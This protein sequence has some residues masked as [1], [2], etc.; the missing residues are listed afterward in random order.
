MSDGRNTFR[1][2]C[3]IELPGNASA[4][5]TDHIN[6]L[7][8]QFP[9]V[10]ASWNRDGKFHLTLKFIGELPHTWVELLSLA[11][12]RATSNLSS[13]NITVTGA[14]AFPEKGSPRVLWLGIDDRTGQLATLQDRLEQEC[15]RE[16]FTREERAFHPHLTIA[17]LRKPDGARELATA[18]AE[19]GFAAVEVS[20]TEL[21]VIRSELSSAGSKYTTISRHPLTGKK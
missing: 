7:R 1:V 2:F 11:A 3:A 15:A 6:R 12:E 13:F 5:V 18:H 20:I 8:N 14:G 10:P 16:N 21:L 9:N 17:R 19:A 4:L